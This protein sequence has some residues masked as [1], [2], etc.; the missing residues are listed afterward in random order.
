MINSP[1]NV[2]CSLGC[3]L[4][5]GSFIT[6]LFP[7]ANDPPVPTLSAV[8]LAAPDLATMASVLTMCCSLWPSSP[9]RSHPWPRRVSVPV[10]GISMPTSSPSQPLCL[11]DLGLAP[12]SRQSPSGQFP[13]LVYFLRVCLATTWKE[14]CELVV[15]VDRGH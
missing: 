6:T 10:M 5:H 15:G 8:G 7:L 11:P 1:C 3:V 2:F 4:V 12:A 14:A 13:S 9:L